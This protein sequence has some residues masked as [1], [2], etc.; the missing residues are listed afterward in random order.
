MFIFLTGC[1]A[2]NFGPKGFGYGQGAGALVHAQWG[3]QK[4]LPALLRSCSKEQESFLNVT[5]Y[6]ETDTSYCSICSAHDFINKHTHCFFPCLVYHT[7]TLLIINSIKLCLLIYPKFKCCLLISKKS[8]WSVAV[9][10]RGGRRMLYKLDAQLC[11]KLDIHSH[12]F[13]SW[14]T[15]LQYHTI[16][17][18]CAKS[19]S[20][21]LHRSGKS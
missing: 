6:C 10:F 15:L 2:K 11:W 16:I 9:Y 8:E 1:Y 4:R 17:Y 7:V 3:G 19:R 18:A 12:G 13:Q 21:S 14:M 20:C 5:N